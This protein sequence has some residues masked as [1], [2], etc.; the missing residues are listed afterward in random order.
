MQ[1]Y[2]PPI[3]TIKRAL[4]ANPPNKLEFYKK[5]DVS[6][7][8]LYAFMSESPRAVANRY[9]VITKIVRYL[10]TEKGVV[11]RV[12]GTFAQ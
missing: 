1:T 4:I 2:F 5:Y 8:W 10:E 6:P 11:F 3:D 7:N 9:E 12:D